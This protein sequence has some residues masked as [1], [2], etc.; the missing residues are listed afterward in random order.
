MARVE[1]AV[2]VLVNQSGEPTGFRWRDQTY[3]VSGRPVRW[4]ARRDWWAESA[5]AYR[6]IGAQ[7]MEREM[8]RLSAKPRQQDQGGLLQFEFAKVDLD[9]GWQLV[10]VY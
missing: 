5:R 7:V 4:F 2:Q 10:R 1:E 6:G 3:Q 9:Q 8:W